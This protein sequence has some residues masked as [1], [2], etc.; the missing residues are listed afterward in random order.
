MQVMLKLHS[1]MAMP[2]VTNGYACSHQWLCLKSPIAM[3]EVTN[4]YAWS[5]Q[6]PY[7]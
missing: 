7:N 1:I 5:H 4:G 6:W 2:A 3:P